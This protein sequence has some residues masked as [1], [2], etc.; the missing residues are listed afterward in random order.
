MTDNLTTRKFSFVFNRYGPP[1]GVVPQVEAAQLKKIR[2]LPTSGSGVDPPVTKLRPTNNGLALQKVGTIHAP[3]T[4][5]KLTEL[6]LK[7]DHHHHQQDIQQQSLPPLGSSELTTSAGVTDIRSP[8]P[9]YPE[10]SHSGKGRGSRPRSKKNHKAPVAPSTP[11]LSAKS[12]DISHPAA[13]QQQPAPT[14]S[15][16]RG[17]LKLFKN[18]SDPKRTDSERLRAKSMEYL[19]ADLADD[20]Q[21]VK[22]RHSREDLSG[23][24]SLLAVT[25][26]GPVTVFSSQKKLDDGDDWEEMPR[27]SSK[28]AAAAAKTPAEA[29]LEKHPPKQFY[30]GM[31]PGDVAV[32]TVPSQPGPATLDLEEESRRVMEEFDAVLS[33]TRTIK[34]EDEP[35]LAVSRK[36][37]KTRR[38]SP[39]PPPAAYTDDDEESQDIALNLRPTLPKKPQQLPRFSPSA[40]WRALGHQPDSLFSRKL[41]SSKASDMSAMDLS[42]EEDDEDVME[43]RINKN[44]RPVAPHPPRNINEKS[45]D[46]G[47]SGDAGSPDAGAMG[48]SGTSRDKPLAMS[49]PVPQQQQNWTP[50]Q[51]LLDDDDSSCEADVIIPAPSSGSKGGKA[52]GPPK[53]IPKSQMFSDSTDTPGS[54]ISGKHRGRKYRKRNENQPADATP[55][56][57][58]SLRKLKRSVSGAFAT[59]FRGGRSSS[60]S[61]EESSLD[62]GNWV[63]T[64]SAPNSV[65]NGSV[66]ESS[67]RKLHRSE[68]DLIHQQI[69]QQQQQNQL[70]HPHPPGGMLIHQ[71]PAYSQPALTQRIVYLPQ[72][73]SRP[74]RS[75]H[76]RMPNDRQTEMMRR[77]RSADALFLES[78]QQQQQAGLQRRISATGK[79]FT[80]QSTVRMQEKRALEARLSRE[81][82]AKERKRLQEVQAM[83]RV[84][85]EFQRK[86]AREKAN[87]RQQLRILQYSSEQ[88]QQTG[89]IAR[90][91]PEGAPSSISH[92][93]TSSD[94]I[95]QAK[96]AVR[97]SPTEQKQPQQRSSVQQAGR[98]PTEDAVRK[99][100]LKQSEIQSDYRRDVIVS[101]SRTRS[102]APPPP[103]QH[104][105]PERNNNVKKPSNIYKRLAEIASE[106]ESISSPPPVP[107]IVV[108]SNKSSPMRSSN[109]TSAV[110]VQSGRR[111]HNAAPQPPQQQPT[112]ASNGKVM[113]QELS[114]YRQERREYRDYRSPR[115][116]VATQPGTMRMHPSKFIS[117]V[118]IFYLFLSFRAL[119]IFFRAA[120]ESARCIRRRDVVRFVLL[121]QDSVGQLPMGIRSRR[122]GRTERQKHVR[123]GS[124]GRGARVAPSAAGSAGSSGPAAPR[125]SSPPSLLQNARRGGCHDA[126]YS[127]AASPS[128]IVL[129]FFQ[130][131]PSSLFF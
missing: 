57:Y 71:Y 34:S 84:E 122:T 17:K 26:T 38:H 46:S 90:L 124:S 23:D 22:R 129:F 66:G 94:E 4:N 55:Q 7:P 80:F 105:P 117:I 20:M 121:R 45:A 3:I 33:D 119:R 40:A 103:P 112:S 74:G 2:V 107:L 75:H 18:K 111:S 67:L 114:E 62:D 68:A 128:L 58:N 118:F 28:S 37:G 130:K 30:F 73:D 15:A 29:S 78:Q 127:A 48:P 47:I 104:P 69:L 32:A 70:M 93:R 16:K 9:D 86:R 100:N 49:S 8:T 72:Y 56:K 39:P 24:E 53:I 120:A 95:Q 89:R 19:R 25:K 50:Q 102:A 5:R 131:I 99:T 116:H 106:E 13:D 21:E 60:K 27:M 123:G 87:I 92:N 52:G 44:S 14:G 82:E 54:S 108:S 83:Q 31:T 85:E 65:V 76:F 61:P 101:S 125:L 96:M 109:N 35:D 88:Q 1:V 97:S 91:D 115:Q 41:D 36:L 81:A 43:E 10:S 12:V 64:R 63:L 11:A 59:A 79:K 77:A 110:V 98:R 51:D 113:T 42:D 126:P 6:Q